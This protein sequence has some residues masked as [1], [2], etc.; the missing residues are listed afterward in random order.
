MRRV[1]VALLLAVSTATAASA[2]SS[3]PPT[4]SVSVTPVAA[5]AGT[6]RV[7]TASGLP[8]ASPVSIVTYDLTGAQTIQTMISAS[9][10]T[11]SAPLNVSDG[12][13]T[14]GMYR[15]VAASG[16]GA[17]TS[18]LFAVTDGSPH[19]VAEPDL[20]SVTSALHVVGWGL[21]ANQDCVVSLELANDRGTRLIDAHADSSGLLSLYVWPQQVGESFYEAGLYPVSIPALGLS[22][23]FVVREH[24][25]QSSMEALS[26]VG[27]D[28]VLHLQLTGYPA[29]RYI[30]ATYERIDGTNAGE[31]LLGQTDS[32]GNLIASASIPSGV[33]AGT[34]LIST[35]YEWG[36]AEFSIP[37][38]P[39]EA[40]ATPAATATATATASATAMPTASAKATRTATAAPT[41]K[42]SSHKITK[43]RRHTTKAHHRVKRICRRDAHGIRHCHYSGR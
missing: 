12:A 39:Q 19:L 38:A 25:G 17:S 18:G 23:Q 16:W 42:I 6:P 27:S 36:E 14:S 40:T 31:A 5:P 30:W 7:L 41:R 43:P 3:A 35:P 26:P 32:V 10:G 15:V 11:L 34:Y 24:P 4:P 13:T 33:D 37:V 1:V 2:Q 22:A 9:D 29:Q 20:P 28:G 8:A 21:P